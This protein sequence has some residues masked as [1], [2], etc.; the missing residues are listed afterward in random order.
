MKSR[1]L[2]KKSI[3]Y[4][5]AFILAVGF[6]SSARAEEKP[7]AQQAVETFLQTIQ[8]MEFPA[9]DAKAQEALIAKADAYLDMNAMGKKALQ[10]HWSELNAEQQ[11][12]Y[13]DLLIKLIDAVAYPRSRKFMGQYQILYPKV[14]PAENGFEVESVIK[15]QEEALDA[16]VNYHLYE[17]EGQWKID[18]IVLDDV[19]IA[20]DLQYQFDK[21]IE[22]SKFEGL[23]AKMNERL[24]Q[25]EK[26]NAASSA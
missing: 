1:S 25:A 10:N 8:S 2:V 4:F 19:S 16:H 9:K 7:A 15:Q 21:L 26:E 13:I 23:I 24:D 14:T 3:F 12:Q 11:K 22:D 6:S 18:D 20:E 17:K 5:L